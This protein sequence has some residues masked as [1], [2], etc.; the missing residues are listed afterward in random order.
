MMDCIRGS[1]IQ[2][3]DPSI[4]QSVEHIAMGDRTELA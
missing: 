2:Y 3:Y 4:S 1:N